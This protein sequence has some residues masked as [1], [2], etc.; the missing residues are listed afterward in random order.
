MHLAC[1]TRRPTDQFVFR[2]RLFE[3]LV[4]FYLIAGYKRVGFIRHADNGH[5]FAKY[6]VGHALLARG[7]GMR[8]DA[9]AALIRNADG[10]VDQLFCERVERAGAHDV[11]DAFPGSAQGGWIFRDRFPKVVDGIGFA[12]RHDVIEDGAH[13]RAR[14]RVLD[15]GGWHG[16][17]CRV[18]YQNTGNEDE[19]AAEAN[20]E[21]GANERRL[22]IVL[23]DPTDGS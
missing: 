5:Q 20:L 12:R 17:L 21:S 15:Q 2:V 10:D 18:A 6:L 13:F 22:H 4:E 9:V 3:L 14:V 11:L 16:P 7:G 1:E 23:P 8:S 19:H